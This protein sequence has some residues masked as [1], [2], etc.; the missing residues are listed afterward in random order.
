MRGRLIAT[1]VLTALLVVIG[2]FSSGT[3]VS[4]VPA[5]TNPHILSKLALNE[6]SIDGPALFES[7]G[8]PFDLIA[9]TGTDPGHHLNIMYS[10]TDFAYAQ[11]ESKHILE[12]TSFARP[13]VVVNDF[14]PPDVVVSIAWVGT[15][16]QHTL[17]VLYDALGTRG[18]PK[19]LTLWG[20]RSFAAPALAM[21]P[22]QAD[23]MILAWAASDANHTLN[24]LPITI[25]ATLKAGTRSTF[26]DFH[27]ATGPSL[28][29]DWTNFGLLLSWST[30]DT[31]HIAFAT[32]SDG[33]RFSAPSTSPLAE[34]TT[35]AP[36][37]FGTRVGGSSPEPVVFPGHF[38]TWTGTDAHHSLN[39]RYTMTF[40]QWG[41][42]A[43][44][45]TI[46]AERCVGGPAIDHGI[47]AWLVV[48]WT[49]TDEW[50]HINLARL[51]V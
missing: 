20:I 34:W 21:I 22:S 47:G 38:V 7:H 3:P 17:N 27:S 5:L 8:A 49:G 43:T 40:P 29:V 15:D 41:D 24:V 30:L 23:T 39:V 14:G 45:K 26:S 19:K 11:D 33:K 12:E 25:G 16:G 1:S 36:S 4:A 37:M 9:W 2:F 35:S 48:V 18:A 50:H 6:R 44:S 46:F 32:S 31:H 13:A 10:H 28:L 42:I 51:G